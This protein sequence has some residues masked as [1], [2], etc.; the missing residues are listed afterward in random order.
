MTQPPDRA[1]PQAPVVAGGRSAV[2]SLGRRR[3]FGR[4]LFA[5]TVGYA[6]ADASRD[7]D[8]T[9]P[10]VGV[11]DTTPGDGTDD[12]TTTNLG[13]AQHHPRDELG[14]MAGPQVARMPGVAARDPTLSPA[15]GRG[16]RAYDD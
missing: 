11:G 13:T 3:N 6:A 15:S 5:G 16:P 14:A 1:R 4:A 12:T 10:T 9:G 2:S 8:L 7:T